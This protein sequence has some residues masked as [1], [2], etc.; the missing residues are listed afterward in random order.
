MRIRYFPVTPEFLI[1]MMQQRES[2]SFR[3]AANGL[4]DDA[5]LHHVGYDRTGM[6]VNVFVAS[7]EF[8]DIEDGAVVPM[9]PKTLFEKVL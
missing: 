7:T 6:W 9:H 3:V 1:M 8:D 2:S 4:P 5:Y